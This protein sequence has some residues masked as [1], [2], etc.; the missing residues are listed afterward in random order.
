M[1]H[2]TFRLIIA[3]ATFLIGIGIVGFWFLNR[4]LPT[5]GLPQNAP[6]CASES[7]EEIS[8]SLFA[9]AERTKT[10]R[11]FREIPLDKPTAGVNESYRL[12]WFPTFDAPTAIRIWRSGEN[13]F[14][15]TKRLS[16]KGGYELGK[17]KSEHTRSLTAEEWNN[18]VNL[19]NN[20]C[21]WNA[22]SVLK[23]IP[24]TDGGFWAFEGSRNKQYHFV[25]RISP[26]EQMK[27]IFRAL[28][29]LTG[30]KTEYN[31]YL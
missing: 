24:A 8:L 3:L 1:K 7:G 21:F 12:I 13:F 30:M 19:I 27:E 23:E 25:E 14:I 17:L 15:V 16:G 9:I 11:L 31:D 18:F 20:R 2:F 5:V 29:E 26:S 6:E 28:F 22:P 4:P 10:L